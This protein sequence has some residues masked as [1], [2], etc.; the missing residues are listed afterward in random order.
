MAFARRPGSR[1]ST[2][3]RRGSSLSLHRRGSTLGGK[4]TDDPRP[5]RDK[6]YQKRMQERLYNFLDS[7]S[8]PFHVTEQMLQSP[9]SKQFLQVTQFLFQQVD[10]G[11]RLGG[12]RWQDDVVRYLQRFGYPGRLSPSSLRSVGSSHAWPPVLA[13]LCWLVELVEY[14]ERVEQLE[15]DG[16]DVDLDLD[17]EAAAAAQEGSQ[18]SAALARQAAQNA[19]SAED[20]EFFRC[21]SDAY[22]NYLGGRGQSD[23]FQSEM[24]KIFEEQRSE[25]TSMIERYRQENDKLREEV[26]RLKEAGSLVEE[27][28][29][30]LQQKHLEVEN[31]ENELTSLDKRAQEVEQ[32]MS[33][34]A[35]QVE[36]LRKETARHRREHE[37][38]QAQIDSQSISQEDVQRILA[39]QGALE[40]EH[41]S[42]REQ[43]TQLD[44]RD[45]A[46]AASNSELRQE[47]QH[48]A[49]AWNDR[50]RRLEIVPESARYAFNVD[51]S[52]HFQWHTLDAHVD[53]DDMEDTTDLSQVRRQVMPVPTPFIA[54]ALAQLSAYLQNQAVPF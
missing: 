17:S 30:A 38:L 40:V 43:A 42:L 45:A 2:L 19:G 12:D 25:S 49:S 15:A 20:R 28:R 37:R 8:Y 31:I 3:D 46:A 13:A 22:A 21:V 10:P 24:R 26:V 11:I 6:R 16:A 18:T 51:L 48:L 34:M 5:V 1:L 35:H 7:H 29:E 33:Q 47:L 27:R 14:Q 52:V 36:A 23:D 4:R 32:E 50:A 41:T 39:R 9:S 54:Q 44:Q 53:R